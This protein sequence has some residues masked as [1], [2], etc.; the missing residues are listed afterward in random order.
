MAKAAKI[1]LPKRWQRFPSAYAKN[2]DYWVFP[3]RIDCDRSS[4][5][6]TPRSAEAATAVR[7][8]CRWSASVCLSDR[9]TQAR[10]SAATTAVTSVL[11]GRWI[12]LWSGWGDA[13]PHTRP[14]LCARQAP[15]NATI[16]WILTAAAA[17]PHMEEGRP[18]VR[19]PLAT[20]A[21]ST[22]PRQGS[23]FCLI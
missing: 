17:L 3:E 7:R 6:T 1:V 13:V 4:H 2:L 10:H 9:S 15:Q 20:A 5:S 22:P 23:P 21:A 19:E 8:S 18:V 16:L 12:S 14:G 11:V